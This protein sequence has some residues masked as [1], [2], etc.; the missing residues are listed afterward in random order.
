M[1][2]ATAIY[3]SGHESTSATATR[4]SISPPAISPTIS[5]RVPAEKDRHND[6]PFEQ[7]HN[8]H[9]MDSPVYKTPAPSTAETPLHTPHTTPTAHSSRQL[10]SQ[11]AFA[12]PSPAHSSPMDFNQRRNNPGT[13]SRRNLPELPQQAASPA[14]YSPSRTP[15]HLG[16]FSDVCNF[17]W[18]VIFLFLLAQSPGPRS[19]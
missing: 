3:N 18:T 2:L 12:A 5:P 15:L 8:K 19:S 13:P 7:V 1:P 16:T 9:K 4:F 6:C 14:N 11:S 17:N 10:P